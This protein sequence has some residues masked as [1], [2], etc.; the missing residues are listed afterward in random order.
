MTVQAHL[1]WTDGLR[2]KALTILGGSCKRA[3]IQIRVKGFSVK[4]V[5]SGN[6]YYYWFYYK[7]GL[8]ELR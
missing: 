6:D 4:D 7:T 1:K 3:Q 2:K 8:P 5:N